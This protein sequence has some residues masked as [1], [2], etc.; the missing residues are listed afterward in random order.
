MDN[1]QF[2]GCIF[3]SYVPVYHGGTPPNI[4]TCSF[5]NSFVGFAEAVENTF[6]LIA[7]MYH[8]GFKDSIEMAIDNM[9][10]DVN[11]DRRELFLTDI[12]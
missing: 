2:Y 6:F 12:P 3:D 4:A 8:G 9:A 10:A 5:K 11:V 1:N 7:K